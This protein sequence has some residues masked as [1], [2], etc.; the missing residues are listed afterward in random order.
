V[1]VKFKNCKLQTCLCSAEKSS[2]N[3]LVTEVLLW[4]KRVIFSKDNKKKKINADDL[5][6]ILSVKQ[7]SK[8][9]KTKDFIHISHNIGKLKREHFCR[10]AMWDLYSRFNVR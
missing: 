2:H 7:L 6:I 5:K 10:V 9:G 4:G 8:K 1:G 3:L